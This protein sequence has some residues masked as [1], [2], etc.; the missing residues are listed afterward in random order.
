M[1][2][3]SLQTQFKVWITPVLVSLL[4]V[5]ASANFAQNRNMKA[6]MDM[7]TIQTAILS[8]KMTS[9]TTWGEKENDKNIATAQ[10]NENRIGVIE[11]TYVTQEL[12][13]KTM[14]D[15]HKYVMANYKRKE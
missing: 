1:T 7:I 12:F 2:Q 6:S 9:H 5:V 14:D 3:D 4:L 13:L 11:R 8:E 10:S 15:F